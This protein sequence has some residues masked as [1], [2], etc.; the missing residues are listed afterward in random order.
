M[1]LPLEASVSG[2]VCANRHCIE[3]GDDL[4]PDSW[5][6][7]RRTVRVGVDGCLTGHILFIT[8]QLE[9]GLQGRT[10]DGG[11]RW[12]SSIWEPAKSLLHA[13]DLAILE[14]TA[15]TQHPRKHWLEDVLP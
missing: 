15:C 13:Q 3:G 10:E 1:P 2:L 5:S 7:F 12:C 11:L 6:A 14:T 4:V 9:A 8:R